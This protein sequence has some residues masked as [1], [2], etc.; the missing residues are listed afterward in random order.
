MTRGTRVL[1]CGR[2]RQSSATSNF[3]GSN[4]IDRYKYSGDPTGAARIFHVCIPVRFFSSSDKVEADDGT[5]SKV[6]EHGNKDMMGQFPWRHSPKLLPR[7]ELENF[8]FN[9][10]WKTKLSIGLW[11]RSTG[12]MMEKKLS[13][14]VGRQWRQDLAEESAWAFCFGVAA[15][16]SNTFKG[17]W[18]SWVL[19]SYAFFSIHTNLPWSLYLYSSHGRYLNQARRRFRDQV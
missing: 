2:L 15:L 13:E 5:T 12:F 8:R 6:Q 14:L 19:D 4:Q 9:K 10:D 17:T 16:L 18:E 1:F 7:I 11:E 3:T